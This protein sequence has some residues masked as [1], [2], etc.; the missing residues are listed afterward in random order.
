MRIGKWA[1][2]IWILALSLEMTGAEHGRE[3]YVGEPFGEAIYDIVLS[4]SNP[5]SHPRA[6]ASSMERTDVFKLRDGRI[7]VVISASLRLSEGYG[8]QKI[9]VGSAGE[10]SKKYKSLSAFIFPFL[11]G[12]DK[13]K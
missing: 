3:I 10:D 8:I 13:S 2:G 1:I 11:P 12:S 9:L 5:I 4:G 7:L 6:Q